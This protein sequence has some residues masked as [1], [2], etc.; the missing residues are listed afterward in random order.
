MKTSTGYQSGRPHDG[1]CVGLGPHLTSNFFF[2]TLE[3]HVKA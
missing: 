2:H 3:E 1:R